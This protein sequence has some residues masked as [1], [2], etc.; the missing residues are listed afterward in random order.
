MPRPF[1]IIGDLPLLEDGLDLGSESRDPG[2]VVLV[3]LGGIQKVEQ[4]LAD[5][6][7]QGILSG[8]VLLDAPSGLKLAST[9]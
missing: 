7:R 3:G 8:E 5:Q 6:A 2:F 4:L 9:L 1:K